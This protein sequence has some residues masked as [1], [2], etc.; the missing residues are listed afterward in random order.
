MPAVGGMGADVLI[1]LRHLSPSSDAPLP[2]AHRDQQ[3]LSRRCRAG[4]ALTCGG[5]GEVIGLIGENGAGKS[6]LMNILG[7]VVQPTAGAIRVDGA[8]RSPF[9]VGDASRPASPS[10]IRS[11]I[12]STISMPPPT[13][14]SDASRSGRPS[15]ADRPQ[16]LYA[17]VRPLL[18]RLGVDFEPDTPV[19]E[20]SLAQRQLLEIVKAMSL[21]ARLVI[22]DEPTSSPD[23]HRDRAADAGHRRAEGGRASASSSSRIA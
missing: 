12:S 1:V 16:E 13:S 22:M 8:E 23:H 19:A 15:E 9:T 2:R 7:G 10:S 4:P 5:A 3:D 18:D 21:D 11:S 14:S 6:T 17:A 20:M